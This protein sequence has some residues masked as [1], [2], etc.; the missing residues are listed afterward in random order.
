MPTQLHADNITIT[1]IQL[2]INMIHFTM[3]L[4]KQSGS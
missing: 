3:S 1:A 2:A 4:N